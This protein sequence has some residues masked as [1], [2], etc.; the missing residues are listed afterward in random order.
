VQLALDPLRTGRWDVLETVD[1]LGS[2]GV[3]V[4]SG[5]MEMEAEDYSTL[6]SIARTGGVRPDATWDANMRAARQNAELAARLGVGLVTFH[7]GFIPHDAGDP[8]RARVTARVREVV[9][10][11]A[12]HGVE[13]AFETGQESAQTLVEFLRELERPRAGV[14]F[15]P[16]NMLLYGMG[17][18]IDSVH[19]LMSRVR[20]VH[21]KDAVPA[22]T[23]GMWGQETPA[24]EGSVD[25]TTFLR[26]V[27][28]AAGLAARPINLLV[29][30]E[31]GES[32]VED[33]RKAAALLRDLAPWAEQPAVAGDGGGGAPGGGAGV[34]A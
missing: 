24:G 26:I 28:Q 31:G 23:P 33:V 1:A 20:Q 5:M 13:V 6:E 4:L 17:D 2:S 19:R 9:D 14:N 29:E 8:E 12:D 16:A 34:R 11:F 25:W 22:P 15:D 27:H 21:V 10:V 32:R 18:P 7:A 3:R 30:R